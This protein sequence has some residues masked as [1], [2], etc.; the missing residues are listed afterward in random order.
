MSAR[1]RTTAVA[2]LTLLLMATLRA[3]PALPDPCRATEG[4]VAMG[5]LL[6][7]DGAVHQRASFSVRGAE[8]SAF[9]G[10]RFVVF[11]ADGVRL[12]IVKRGDGP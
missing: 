4:A 11:E 2:A 12:A 9:D 7:V 3:T 10:V 1:A 8:L 5:P 6:C